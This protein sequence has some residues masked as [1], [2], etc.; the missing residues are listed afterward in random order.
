MYSKKTTLFAWF[1]FDVM[2]TLAPMKLFYTPDISSDSFYTLNEEESKHA[3]RVL[4]LKTGDQ[5]TLIDGKG[6]FFQAKVHEDH[7]K[8]CVV[9]ILHKDSE[10]TSLP[11]IHIAIAPTK[12]NDRFEWFI[13][14]ATEIGIQEITP[15]VCEHAERK[16]I[17]LDRLEKK[18]ISAMKQ[19]LKARLPII[20]EA[21][22][23]KDLISK[24]FKGV[25][26]IAHC[27]QNQQK[28]LK[29]IYNPGENTLILI[30]PEGDFSETE[31][32]MAIENGFQPVT[33]GKSRLRTETAG[34]VACHT[35]NLLNE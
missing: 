8:K 31:I 32:K 12:N 17:N 1:F 28:H 19:S 11:L 20:H 10:L 6:H 2:F 7:P 35:I 5:I 21:T 25:K 14:K 18:A 24:N 34:I 3:I 30:G 33:F 22:S 27:Y 26:Y 9:E 13:E 23:F 4:R 16:N 15:L 29:E